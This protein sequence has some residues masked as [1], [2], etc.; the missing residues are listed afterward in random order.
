MSNYETLKSY[1]P[2][3]LLEDKLFSSVLETIAEKDLDNFDEALVDVL[4]QLFPQTATWGLRLWEEFCGIETN[5]SV[6]I[7]LRRADVISKLSRDTPVTPQVIKKMLQRYVADVEINQHYAEYSFDVILKTKTTLETSVKYIINQLEDIKPCHLDYKLITDYLTV[8]I[9]QIKFSRYN[10]VELTKC[11]TIDDSGNSII[12][13]EGRT[14]ND[15]GIDKI[16]KYF[17]IELLSASQKLY[18]NG[19][20]GKS[21][22][23]N[24]KDM[25]KVYFSNT[26]QQAS[27]NTVTYFTDGVRKTESLVDKKSYYSSIPFR[28]VSDSSF[29]CMIDGLSK[30]EK[31]ID[32]YSEYFSHPFQV[33]M[34][35]DGLRK[36]EYITDKLSSYNSETFKEASDNSL[37]YM[38]D[39][40]RESEKITDKCSMFLSVDIL[41]CST[42]ICCGGGVYA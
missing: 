24:I 23:E 27:N 18:P 40:I 11:G 34:G 33:A 38:S 31:V 39:G 26:L 21:F 22:S 17:S 19:S 2:P 20:L 6:P 29:I 9:M 16:N 42:N 13:T 8:L 28:I 25:K 5:V 36:T 37:T 41:Q 4:L 14:Y 1:L 35:S 10:S 12:A 15:K 3:F 32:K 7:E 30:N